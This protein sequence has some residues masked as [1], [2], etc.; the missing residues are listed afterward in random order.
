[1]DVL[2]VSLSSNTASIMRGGI[3][4]YR[5]LLPQF[6]RLMNEE[7]KER[8]SEAEGLVFTFPEAV[9]KRDKYLK[10]FAYWKVWGDP[11]NKMLFEYEKRNIP[12]EA[13]QEGGTYI[14]DGIIP[15]EKEFTIFKATLDNEVVVECIHSQNAFMNGNPY[16]LDMDSRYEHEDKHLILVNETILVCKVE[17][18]GR[19]WT[20]VSQSGKRVDVALNI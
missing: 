3:K 5:P 16:W 13:L 2:H 1:M 11:R 6:E 9:L 14:F 19:M 12:H 15:Q 17:I 18:I 8:Y 4:R 20:I 10:D 7:L